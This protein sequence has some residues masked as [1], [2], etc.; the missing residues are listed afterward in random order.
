MRHIK[1]RT[2][3]STFFGLA[4]YF[5]LLLL[6]LS[7]TP[8]ALANNSSIIW[9]GEHQNSSIIGPDAYQNSSATGPYAYITN[10]D[11]ATVHII[12]TA[13]N[14]VIDTVDI[15]TSPTYEWYVVEP[16][17]VA[18]TP[19]GTKVYVTYSGSMAYMDSNVAVIDTATNTLTANVSVR[20]YPRGVAVSPDGTKAYVVSSYGSRG[21]VSVIDTATDIV[22]TTV[23]VGR[24]PQGVTVTPDGKEVY[25]AN[26]GSDTVSVIDTS[27]NKLKTTVSVKERCKCTYAP[28][29]VTIT[30]DG[31][32]VYVTN[33]QSDI[34]S[35]ID[36]AKKVVTATVPVGDDPFGV[37]VAREK[38]YVANSQSNNVT[39]I[40]ISS[41][42]VIATVNV[43][44]SPKGIAA[45]PDGSKVYVT[46][47]QGNT[48]SVID[49]TT[50]TVIATVSAGS[51]P[52]SFGQ[53]I[54]PA[55]VEQ[56]LPVANFSSNV[57]E[58]YAPLPVQ[59]TDLSENATSVNWDFGDGNASSEQNPV[60][61]YFAAGNYTVNLTAVNENG[62]SSMAANITVL[63]EPVS[64]WDFSPEE[65]VSGD[66]LNIKGSAFPGEKVDIFV[67]FEKTVPVSKGKFE[68]TIDEV[69]IPEG[70]NNFFSVEAEGA[71]NLNVRVKKV[72]WITKSSEASGDSA[73]V[74]QSK[75][76]PGTYK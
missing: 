47:Y 21:F 37:T 62:T 68:Y 6:I 2:R 11:T 9:Q 61:T 8:V 19:D 7:T 33:Y 25:V 28:N 18:I 53:F 57:T 3:F 38:V 66:V 31:S 51:Y 74:S 73:I 50:D 24:E 43:G 52:C 42:K 5:L 64:H 1:T 4:A 23:K 63:E 35:V 16:F 44:C 56:V 10:S 69:K 40:D 65:P 22:K 71:K 20:G 27:R 75:V 49:T 76:P 29:G 55:L 48:V 46:N 17:G 39:I 72:I 36:T 54:G 30:P 45:T 26:S 13:T 67:N 12:D 41:N 34:V 59:F 32:K 70:L 14:T 60:H 58:G 15:E